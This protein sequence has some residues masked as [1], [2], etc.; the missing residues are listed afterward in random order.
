MPVNPW[1]A[2]PTR[3]ELVAFGFVADQYH[4]SSICKPVQTPAITA[5]GE[6]DEPSPMQVLAGKSKFHAAGLLQVNSTYSAD[7]RARPL[8]SV[9]DAARLLGVS[10]ATVYKLCGDGK[11]P[12]TRILSAIRI[13]PADLAALVIA[14]RRT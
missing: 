7:S 1:E 14:K 5:K 2:R 11:L 6:G 8:V 12:H 3:F 10:A 4:Q 13:V 9:R